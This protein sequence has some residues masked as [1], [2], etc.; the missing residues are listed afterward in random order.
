MFSIVA[1]K[2]YRPMQ[3][4]V[5]NHGDKDIQELINGF[6]SMECVICGPCS[7]VEMCWSNWH[8]IIGNPIESE[9]LAVSTAEK[10]VEENTTLYKFV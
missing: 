6:N 10:L 1:C 2:K 8:T 9:D 3:I 4:R 5:V 7:H